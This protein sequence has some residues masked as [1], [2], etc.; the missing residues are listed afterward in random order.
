MKRNRDYIRLR[1]YRDYRINNLEA[2]SDATLDTSA[3]MEAV[4]IAEKQEDGKEISEIERK[5]LSDVKKKFESFL[6]DPEVTEKEG[7]KEALD[8]TIDEKKSHIEIDHKYKEKSKT[9]R[10]EIKKDKEIEKEKEIAKEKDNKRSLID[11]FADL[12]DQ[13][14]DYIDD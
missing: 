10:D 13:M 3:L 8:Y 9:I 4:A 14:P 2:I 12:N 11:D 7:L 1:R 5:K 6:D